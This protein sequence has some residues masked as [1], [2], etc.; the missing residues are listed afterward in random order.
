MKLPF[1]VPKIMYPLLLCTLLPLPR[2][3]HLGA[4]DVHIHALGQEIL[5]QHRLG[6]SSA[7]VWKGIAVE[8]CYVCVF[9]TLGAGQTAKEGVALES[10][11]AHETRYGRVGV[12]A[13]AGMLLL[14]LLLQQLLQLLCA[15]R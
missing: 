1:H 13:A 7:A 14:L 8:V 11:V 6:H 4:L 5:E 9:I 15:G 3:L 10:H 12:G 2:K